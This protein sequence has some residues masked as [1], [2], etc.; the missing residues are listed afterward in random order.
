MIGNPHSQCLSQQLAE[1]GFLSLLSVL[2][3]S[4]VT[5]IETLLDPLFATHADKLCQLGVF[6]HNDTAELPRPT[7]LD[8]KLRTVRAVAKCTA[9]AEQIWGS[10]VYFAGDHA[11]YKSPRSSSDTAWHQD[12]A[13]DKN[14]RKQPSL[15]MWIPLQ[16]VGMNGGCMRF[17]LGSHLGGLLPHIP[18]DH[19]HRNH[20]KEAVGAEVANAVECPM[21]VGDLSV[22][23]PRTVH[24]TGANETNFPRKAWILSF[25]PKSGYC[26]RRMS[27]YVVRSL[28][29][30]AT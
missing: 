30:V 18:R 11:I 26:W 14:W 23:L 12:E 8:P 6:G 29:N 7:R 27:N 2:D 20:A 4:D 19:D 17:L 28:S 15:T 3:T 13:Y 9:L 22:H 16:S 25:T 24:G 5:Q 21:D 1:N 10:P